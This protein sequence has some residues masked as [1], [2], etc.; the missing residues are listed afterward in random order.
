MQNE[1]GRILEVRLRPDYSP[2]IT[3][4]GIGLLLIFIRKLRK[5]YLENPACL[6][7]VR[8]RQT[9]AGKSCLSQ[10]GIRTYHT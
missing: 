1:R 6:A 8:R 2:T 3:L 5:N 9:T 4:L 10:D 7:V